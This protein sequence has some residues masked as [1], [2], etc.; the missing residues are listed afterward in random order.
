MINS[1]T[2]ISHVD[3]V[4]Q[5]LVSMKIYAFSTKEAVEKYVRGYHR[6]FGWTFEIVET[7]PEIKEHVKQFRISEEKRFKENSK[8]S[9]RFSVL[10]K[11]T[12][13]TLAEAK[14]YIKS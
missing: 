1:Y 8:N 4:D 9:K 3:H 14:R 11:P 6:T 7:T 12:P 5:R 10:A 2:V 13:W